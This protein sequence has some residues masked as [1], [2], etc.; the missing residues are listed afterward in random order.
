MKTQARRRFLRW[1]MVAVIGHL[2]VAVTSAAFAGCERIREEFDIARKGRHLADMKAI[3]GDLAV[4]SGCDNTFRDWVRL[5]VA[6][7]LARDAR[8][9]ITAGAPIAN[10]ASILEEALS[11]GPV[12]Q[13]AAWLGDIAY[14]AGRFAD[15]ARRYQEALT[16]IADV[17]GTPQP[18]PEPVIE[19][20]FRRAELARL[21]A[22]DY[23]PIPTTRAGEPS[24]LGSVSVRGFV[25]KKVAVPIE[26]QFGSTELT[27]R[28]IQAAQDLLASLTSANPATVKLV[29]HT[30]PSGGADYNQKLSERRASAIRDYLLSKGFHGQIAV[31]GRGYNEPLKI[32]DRSHF[33][34]DQYNQMLRRVEVVR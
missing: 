27:G 2:S 32:D 33:T 31:E 10:Q 13:A 18:P 4:T 11:Y 14:D 17:Q 26:F 6:R 9:K 24:G 1:G 23:V 16:A 5:T 20:V 28:G 34:N 30:D 3:A 7:E 19:Q 8:D 29:G 21:A 12:W 25:P 15:A 22:A